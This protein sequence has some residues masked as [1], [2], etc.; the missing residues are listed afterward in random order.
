MDYQEYR[1]HIRALFEEA[2]RVAAE[3]RRRIASPTSEIEV[4][5][6]ED[7]AE[8]VELL[9]GPKGVAEKIRRYIRELPPEKLAFKL[10]EELIQE[11]RGR[12]NEDKLVLQVIRTSLAILTPPCITAAPTEGIVDAKIKKNPDGT[13]YI[14]VYFAGPIRSAGGTELAA[15]VLLADY[16]RNL[17]NLD[18]YKPTEEEILRFIEELRTY[19][20]RVS[21]FQYSVPENIIEFILRNLPV[22][23]TGIAT[24]KIIASSF[25]DLPKIETNYLRGGALRVVNDG[26]AG[27]AKK[28]LKLVKDLGIEGWGWIEE[29]AKSIE[30]VNNESEQSYLDELVGGRPFISTPEKFGGLRIRYGK[31]FATGMQA[32]GLHPMTIKVLDGYLVTGT[33]LKLDYPGK[34]GIVIPVDPIEPPIIL[35]E[36]GDVVKIAS[37]EIFREVN[38]KIKKILFLGDILISIGDLIENN[39][40][41]RVPGYCE[42]WWAEDLRKKL[43]ENG[44]MLPSG[45]AE[46]TGRILENPVQVKPAVEDAIKLSVY[47][48]IPLHPAHLPFWRRVGVEDLEKIRKW[49]VEN[50]RGARVSD[51]SISLRGTPEA[52]EILTSLLI[53]H[54]VVGE[55]IILPLRWFKVLVAC[56]RPFQ[57]GRRLGEGDVLAAIEDISGIP[58]RDKAGSF[59]GARMGRPEK[60]AQ[61]E[62]SPPVNLLFP[63][64][65][66]EGSSRDIMAAAKAG[67][68]SVVELVVRK[69]NRCG[70][71][72]WRDKCPSCERPT[73]IIGLCANCGNEAAYAEDAECPRCGGRIE[74][75]RK[76]MINFNEE[77]YKALKRISEGAPQ[78]LRGVKGL[79]SA[80]KVPESLEKGI[81]RAKYDLYIYKDGTIRFDATNAPLT[82][83]TPSQIKVPVEKLRELGYVRDIYG[84]EL[85]SPD[86]ILEL[87]LQDVVIPKKA[88]EHLL[89]VS[90]FIDEILVKLAG[91]P[92]FY[93]MEN[94]N[95]LLGTLIVALSPHT[96]AGVVGRIIGF[97]DSLVCFAHPIFHAAKRRDCDGDEDSIMLLLDPLIN[98]SK[99]YLPN[100]VGGK[101]DSPL[102]IT[103]TINP[104]EVD[105]QAHNVD[106]CDRIPPEFYDAAE[107]GKH[108][109]EVLDVIPTIK[110]LI[111]KGGEIRSG[112]THP[113]RS[114]ES[115]PLESSYKRYG[116]MLEKIM[117]QMKLAERISAVDIHYVAEKMAETHLLSDI[118]GNARAFFL[119]KFRCKKCGTRYRRLPLTV[120]CANCGGEISQTVF[121]GAVEKYIELV[122]GFLLK[123]IQNEYLKQR[124]VIAVNNVK[125]TFGKVGEEQVS[126]EDFI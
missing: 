67:K 104:E 79:N 92:A 37:E 72:T 50:I 4:S 40:R 93:K 123:N 25:R 13:R 115:S 17:L 8:R 3:A 29:V 98:F 53:E 107:K 113:Q 114:L 96:Y 97:T 16:V 70:E 26:I 7:I 39:V 102:L 111:E 21:R 65:E 80:A 36:D 24:D 30:L 100:R 74:Y 51:G 48:K 126:L 82:H 5:L 95:D 41:I 55:K 22:E 46:L 54:R 64:G 112:F 108:I 15:I 87:K 103:V 27:R 59:I 120:R 1:Q 81:L 69:C 91:M 43:G 75:S 42:E 31:S 121:R 9:V 38:G 101:M 122:E 28:V 19:Q 63:V 44:G 32:V 86:Q 85:V 94:I 124:I 78:K 125:A 10:A 110:S 77:L 52:K 68:K 89:K 6:A 61:R 33:Q 35:T 2:Y 109:S 49:I 14:A 20:R 57:P 84:R 66:L 90:K 12:M 62:M 34:G 116:S 47:L 11:L 117:G 60:A 56:L 76:V 83:F 58:Q 45:L 105:E 23:V 118:L 88:A 99:H 106:I 119:Q 73:E 71:A 18:R